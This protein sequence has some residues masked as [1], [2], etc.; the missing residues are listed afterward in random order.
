MGEPYLRGQ[1]WSNIHILVY[2]FMGD[3][4]SRGQGQSKDHT[5]YFTS[6]QG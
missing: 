4:Y 2:R 3:P 5:I 1:G 6:R